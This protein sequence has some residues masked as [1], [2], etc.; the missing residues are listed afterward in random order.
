MRASQIWGAAIQSLV[1][2]SALREAIARANLLTVQTVVPTRDMTKTAL[3]DD[4]S[5]DMSL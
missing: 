3:K 5:A 2:R 4:K 1:P